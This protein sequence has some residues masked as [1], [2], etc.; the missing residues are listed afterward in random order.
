VARLK[1][2]DAEEATPYLFETIRALRRELDRLRQERVGRDIGKPFR[3][4]AD[5]VTRGR[6][7]R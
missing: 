2:T 1:V 7:I 5:E 4:R 3:Q 6:P